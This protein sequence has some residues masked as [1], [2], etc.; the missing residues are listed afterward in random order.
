MT[1]KIQYTKKTKSSTLSVGI[2]Q[3]RLSRNIEIILA[4]ELEETKNHLSTQT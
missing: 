2:S 1:T 3:R 4:A